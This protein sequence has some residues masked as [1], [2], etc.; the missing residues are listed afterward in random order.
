MKQKYGSI[1]D[2]EVTYFRLMVESA[3]PDIKTAVGPFRTEEAADQFAAKHM[4]GKPFEKQPV[5]VKGLQAVK[6][7]QLLDQLDKDAA[8]EKMLAERENDP[9]LKAKIKAYMQRM[10]GNKNVQE[11]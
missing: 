11:R 10:W 4:E 8:I 2:L 1:K 9:K 7:L 6:I 3:Q 5:I